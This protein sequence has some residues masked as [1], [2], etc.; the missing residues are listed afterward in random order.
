MFAGLVLW[1]PVLDLRHTFLQPELPWGVENFGPAQ[2]ELLQRQGYL[3]V[4][5]EFAL[6]RVLFEEF[7]RYR[8]AEPFL[9]SRQP[10]LVVHGDKDSY[11]SY[12]IAKTAAQARS[13]LPRTDRLGCLVHP[14]CTYLYQPSAGPRR[15]GGLEPVRRHP[16]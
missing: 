7:G 10:A 5:G 6:G 16:Q 14:K 8:P 9:T 2:R 3:L 4:D 15:R 1:N 12:D 11:V 13:H